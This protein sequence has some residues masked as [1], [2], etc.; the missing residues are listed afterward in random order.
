MNKVSTP[1]AIGIIIAAILLVGLLFYR[2]VSK[3]ND[4]GDTKAIAA[5]VMKS[6]PQGELP[7]GANPTQGATTRGKRGQ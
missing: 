5:D 2:N 1:V 7:A 4:S 6:S 3:A